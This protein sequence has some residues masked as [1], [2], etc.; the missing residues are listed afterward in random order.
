VRIPVFNRIG[1]HNQGWEVASINM[2]LEHGGGGNIAEDRTFNRLIGVLKELEWDGRPLIQ[3]PEV[4]DL[5]GEVV[6]ERETLRLFGLRNYWG[7]QTKQ[8]MEHE[9]PQLSYWTKKNSHAFAHKIQEMLGMYTLT[10]DPKYAVAQGYLELWQ[11]SCFVEVHYGGGLNIQATVMARRLGLGR[12]S[13]E[14]AARFD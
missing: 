4:R 2:E 8:R 1:A 11:R 12:N 13:R 3:D 9:G 6:Q 7:A 10:R 14:E 5:L